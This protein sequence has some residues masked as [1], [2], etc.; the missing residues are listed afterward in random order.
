M[1]NSTSPVPQVVEGSNAVAKINQIND[2]NSQ[3][4]IGG[5]DASTTAL[6]TWGYLG[7]RIGGI[8]V[9]NGTVTL[10]ASST[11]YLVMAKATGVVSVSTATT[12]W[13]DSA[14]YWRLYQITVGTTAPTSYLDERTSERGV[15]GIGAVPVAG[16]TNPMT[17]AAD[18][19]VGATSG[20]A[21]RIAKGTAYQGLRMNSGA[22]AQEWST[23]VTCIPIACSDET[24]AIGVGTAKVTFHM[25]FAMVLTEVF[26]GLTTA[27]SSGS[28]FTVDIN[29]GGTT[30]LST[31]ITIDNTEETSLTAATPPVISDSSLAKGAKITIDVDQVG[32]GTA[33]GL[34]V[35]LTGYVAQ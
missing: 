4:L 13:N 31:K 7:G 30:I 28:I 2:A 17:D 16:F 8:N 24:T 23:I 29:E 3:G 22:T 21:D 10:T 15:F 26:A 33:A 5:R 25:P 14:N 6:L 20:V 18:M 35:Y 12:N 11:N 34:K 1:A 19:I 32:S 27:Q 9:S